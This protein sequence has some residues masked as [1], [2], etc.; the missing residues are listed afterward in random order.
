MSWN[1][2]AGVEVGLDSGIS[3]PY[4]MSTQKLLEEVP[5]VF[6]MLIIMAL[7]QGA[8]WHF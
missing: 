6:N 1:G 2:W 8:K 5:L 3:V 7:S 4:P